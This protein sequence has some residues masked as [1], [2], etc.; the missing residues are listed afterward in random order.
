MFLAK[1]DKTLTRLATNMPSPV[2]PNYISDLIVL[3]DSKVAF[4]AWCFSTVFNGRGLADFASLLA[5]GGTSLGH[6]RAYYQHLVNYGYEYTFL[7]RGRPASEINS[8][9]V[10]D[11]PPACWEDMIATILV[12]EN[13]M[14]AISSGFVGGKDLQISTLIRKV[15]QERYF[16]VLY[17]M[18]WLGAFEN[19]EKRLFGECL[20]RRLNSVRQ[21]LGPADIEDSTYAAGYR[22]TSNNSVH[23]K[24]EAS[25]SKVYAVLDTP[26]PARYVEPEAWDRGRRRNGTVPDGLYRK[27][28]PREL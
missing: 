17:A 21:W 16:H 14:W 18:G 8:M 13:A 7:E 5:L 10:L 22:T 3:G 24:F 15:G 25:M 20:I 4:S 26:P 11:Q 19:E 28:K 27:M 1:G 2:D 9:P 6:A 23:E 12:A